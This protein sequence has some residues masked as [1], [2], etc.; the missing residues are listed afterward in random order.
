M[1]ATQKPSAITIYIAIIFLTLF[2]VA[3]TPNSAPPNQPTNHLTSQP[4]SQP[5][6]Q[7][8]SQPPSPSPT[9]T[10]MPEE[11]PVKLEPASAQPDIPLVAGSLLKSA[12]DPGVF[13]L[14]PDGTRLHIYDWPT[15]LA[16]GF[17]EEDIIIV[18][19]DQL[20]AIPLSGEL[21][22]LVSDTNGQ[23]FQAADGT[24]RPLAGWD[25]ASPDK[26]INDLPVSPIEPLLLK[27]MELALGPVSTLRVAASGANLRQG[28]GLDYAVVGYAEPNALLFP[29]ARNEDTSWFEVKDSDGPVWIAASVTTFGGDV[30]ALPIH[31]SDAPKTVAAAPTA[32]PT[33]G[34]TPT[35]APLTC[36]EVPIRGFG[37]VWADHPE[38]QPYLGCPTTWMPGEYGTNAAVQMFERGLMVWV[39]QDQVQGVDPVYVLFYD[40]YSF[41]RFRDLG[42]ADPAKVGQTDPGYFA[43][44]D[45]FSKVYWEGTGAKV[46][47]RLG[48]A[49]GAA[50]D[51]PGAFQ[52]FRRGRML[53][54]GEID[55]VFVIYD[56]YSYHNQQSIQVK[57]WAWYED[58]F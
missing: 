22:R 29:L 40:D 21:T 51:S 26:T 35:P 19:A 28:P 9:T 53:W 10:P 45:K 57:A 14:K 3:C 36:E 32:T 31:H 43:V 41:Q 23:L 38:I 6:N 49:T 5:T 44:G 25:Q 2:M 8:A 4:T 56:Y 39:E 7:P 30:G 27:R 55:H 34:P 17:K 24:L 11:I 46:K 52:T 58:T 48:R 12:D 33:P 42:S 37:K 16:Y 20:H 18:P 54:V 1:R 47:E 50:Q 13:W 15:F